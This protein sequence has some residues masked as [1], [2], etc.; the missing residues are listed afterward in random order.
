MFPLALLMVL[1]AS[2]DSATPLQDDSQEFLDALP[3]AI[4]QGLRQVE[5][6]EL[7]R[8]SAE[9]ITQNASIDSVAAGWQQAKQ[10]YRAG[11]PGLLQCG[12]GRYGSTV[13]IVGPDGAT[14]RFGKSVLDI[15]PGALLDPVVI[16]AEELVSTEVQVRLSPHGLQFAQHAQLTIDHSRCKLPPFLR[17]RIVYTDDSLQVLEW[18]DP[19]VDQKG[20]VQSM[21]DHFSRYAV[22]F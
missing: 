18:M 6:A 15:P 17:E 10:N 14:L 19:A 20:R 3:P 1:A 7:T 5:S 21:I 16:T 9:E 4:L 12:P 22:A 11:T 2:C 13:R 8:I